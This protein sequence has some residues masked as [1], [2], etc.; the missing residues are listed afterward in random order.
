M[1]IG[2]TLLIVLG[3]IIFLGVEWANPKTFG[4][5]PMWDKVMAAIF[6]SVTPR[7]AG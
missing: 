3:V 1:L 2:T 5:L 6:Q 4:P 7:T